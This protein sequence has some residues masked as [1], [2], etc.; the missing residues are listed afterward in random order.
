MTNQ[1]LNAIAET[2]AITFDDIVTVMDDACREKLYRIA[3]SEDYG[4]F[5]EVDIPQR[6]CKAGCW[7]VNCQTTRAKTKNKERVTDISCLMRFEIGEVEG[8]PF[9]FSRKLVIKVIDNKACLLGSVEGTISFKNDPSYEFKI[10]ILENLY[11]VLPESFIVDYF[12][13]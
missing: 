9:A 8:L 7:Y 1:K 11:S 12:C 10:K 4:N 3:Y 2:R 6:L 13:E 5:A